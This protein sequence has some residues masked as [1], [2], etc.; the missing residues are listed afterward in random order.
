ML[1]SITCNDVRNERF[2][3]KN[4]KIIAKRKTDTQNT[5]DYATFLTVKCR[6][7]IEGTKKRPA[8]NGQV[9]LQIMS[10]LTYSASTAACAAA[11][12]AMGTR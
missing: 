11:R 10:E 2:L 7:H 8:Q 12:R 9:P 1:F 4:T 3:G 6:K 5:A